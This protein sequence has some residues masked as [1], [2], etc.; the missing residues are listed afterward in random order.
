MDM[1]VEWW[2]R[3]QMKIDRKLNYM[4][5]LAKEISVEEDLIVF[6]PYQAVRK[7]LSIIDNSISDNTS[8][9]KVKVNF[10]PFNNDRET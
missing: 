9:K 6:T 3:W 1:G 10:L 7:P 5:R 4:E 8:Q 2:L